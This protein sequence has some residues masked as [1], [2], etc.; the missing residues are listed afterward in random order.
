MFNNYKFFEK[1]YYLEKKDA[2]VEIKDNAFQKKIESH[3]RTH[4]NLPPLN[5]AREAGFSAVEMDVD[6]AIEINPSLL[7][8]HKENSEAI[9]SRLPSA[10]A[11]PI[12]CL[13]S[14]E[15]VIA[16][17]N[18]VKDF[19]SEFKPKSKSRVMYQ[20]MVKS[21]LTGV[22][23]IND[24][25]AHLESCLLKYDNQLVK[26]D[27]SIRVDRKKRLFVI[28]ISTQRGDIQKII[29][30]IKSLR[31][32]KIIN[33]NFAEVGLNQGLCLIKG[34]ASNPIHAL[35]NIA[36]TEDT[37]GFLERD[38]GLTSGLKTQTYQ[39]NHWTFN[40]YSNLEEMQHRTGY[41]DKSYAV[42]LVLKP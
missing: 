2:L 20:I 6:K 10:P 36:N 39:D 8:T 34:D 18:S 13:A 30:S 21:Y 41:S 35:V 22:T 9:I 7:E 28:E 19:V 23:N 25:I 11:L 1:H 12:S 24:Q 42:K 4:H 40:F 16:M 37:K 5:T 17:Q 38:A 27:I 32:F 33:T 29:K 3:M 14:A 31:N 26:K 15:H